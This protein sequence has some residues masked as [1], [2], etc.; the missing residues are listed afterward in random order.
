MAVTGITFDNQSVTPKNDGR[1][2]RK[3][4]EDGIVTG[5]ELTNSGANLNIAA[6]GFIVCGRY[7][8][9]AS[10]T[11]VAIGEQT[12]GYARVRIVLDMTAAATS[13][14]FEQ[15]YFE[16]DYS[17]TNSFTA[18]TQEDINAAGSTY[19]FE[20]CVV[21]LD[22][23]GI[24]SIVSRATAD[25][26]KIY[27]ASASAKMVW[28]TVS[29]TFALTDAGTMQ[30]INSSSNLTVTIPTNAAVP[31]PIGTEIEI[32]RYNTGTVTIAGS[33]GVTLLCS[34]TGRAIM[35][36]YTSAIIKKVDTNTWLLQGSVG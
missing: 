34:V 16:V 29:K 32:L 1:I 8:E 17:A 36:R 10:T 15:V 9:L 11:T 28:S 27:A 7:F 4:L 13:E 25:S 24:A 19:E 5:C 20:L 26:T 30:I 2:Y 31:F 14:T 21:S 23:G 6:G 35:F 18:L 3:L 22:A 33:S 12:R